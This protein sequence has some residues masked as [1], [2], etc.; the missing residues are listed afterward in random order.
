MARSPNEAPIPTPRTAAFTRCWHSNAYF[1]LFSSLFF[2]DSTEQVSPDSAGPFI[3]SVLSTFG[4]RLVFRPISVFTINDLLHEIDDPASE[5]RVLDPR[6]CFC[7]HE[8]VRRGEEVGYIGR[9]RRR[10][11]R[12]GCTWYAR[13]AFEE[14]RHR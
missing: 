6:E 11:L 4:P 8:P 5:L 9:R 7:E 14:E 10:A 1:S 3:V 12:L 13:R 2:F